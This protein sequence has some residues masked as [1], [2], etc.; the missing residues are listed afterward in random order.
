M[1]VEQLGDK[2]IVY[3]FLRISYMSIVF[4]SFSFFLPPPLPLLLRFMDSSILSH[5]RVPYYIRDHIVF[6]IHAW[7]G[8]AG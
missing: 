6:L 1:F 5:M 2:K 4:L 8:K 3:L 7:V